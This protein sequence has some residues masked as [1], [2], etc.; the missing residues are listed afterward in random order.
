MTIR[1]PDAVIVRT[2]TKGMGHTISCKDGILQFCPSD[3]ARLPRR[4]T[5]FLDRDGV[6][7]RRIEGGYVTRWSDFIVLRG[8]LSA[9]RVLREH[10][11]QVVIVSNQAGVGKGL[12]TWERLA[13]I[14]QRSLRKFALAGGSV[15]AAFFCLHQPS[16]NCNCRK[17]KPGLLQAAARCLEIDFAHSFLIGDSPA[18]IAAGAAM[19]CT[20]IYLSPSFDGTVNACHQ[21]RNLTEAVRWITDLRLDV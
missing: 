17:P 20:T 19:K 8:V 10:N 13:R 5:V 4:A 3:G 1:R 2:R 11:F 21:A 16:D 14:T 18:D 6:L 9:L 12:V 15:D 7:N